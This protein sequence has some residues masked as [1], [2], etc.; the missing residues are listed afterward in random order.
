MAEEGK[1][2]STTEKL[3][4]AGAKAPGPWK[5]WIGC[6]NFFFKSSC[7]ILSFFGVPGFILGILA[8][9]GVV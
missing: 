7:F 9:M 6:Y 2:Q 4:K 3:L 5:F 1:E 8:V